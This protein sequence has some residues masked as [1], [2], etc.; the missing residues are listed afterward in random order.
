MK[1]FSSNRAVF[2]FENPWELDEKD[3]NRSSVLPFVEGVAKFIGDTEVYHANFFNKNTLYLALDCLCKQKYKNAIV[4]IAAHG[5]N[6]KIGSVR[7]ENVLKKIGE[8]SVRSNIKGV[9]L[10][11]C[12]VGNQTQTMES[13]L[14]GS[15]LNWC[16]GYSEAINWLPGTMIDCSI[17]ASML[18]LEEKDFSSESIIQEKFG[19]AISSFSLFSGVGYDKK[20]KSAC[21]RDA[22]KLVVHASGRG[23]IPRHVSEE[24]FKHHID[25]QNLRRKTK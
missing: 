7:I 6:K 20:N 11:S 2:I 10:G 22:L 13:S 17:I 9:L 19:E 4:Y 12:F 8:N 1:H 3:S 14:S 25:E 15:N 18:Q 21:L 24:I 16:A 23:K 5:S